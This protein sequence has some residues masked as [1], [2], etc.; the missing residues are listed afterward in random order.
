[1]ISPYPSS[2]IEGPN[3]L[4]R[5]LH[6]S[7]LERRSPFRRF[8]VSLP[9]VPCGWQTSHSPFRTTPIELGRAGLDKRLLTAI[10][11][12]R[13]Y[14]D[15]VPRRNS[16]LAPAPFAVAHSPRTASFD[17]G[18]TRPCCGELAHTLLTLSTTPR[19]GSGGDENGG[20]G[21]DNA[22]SLSCSCPQ[23]LTSFV[24]LCIDPHRREIPYALL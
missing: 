20:G 10:S 12:A 6:H 1:M 22:F 19:T 13:D 16:C 9:F 21:A 11:R 7:S 18:A 23:P 3:L 15:A 8:I 17:Y 5:T 24:P 14:S 2:E 4:S